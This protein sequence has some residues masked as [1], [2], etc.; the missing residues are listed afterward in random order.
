MVRLRLYGRCRI[1]KDPVSP[2][3]KEP[4]RIGWDGWFR[5][6]EL[7]TPRSLRGR[8]L[9]MRTRGWWT[10]EPSDVAEVVERYGGLVVGD[11]GELMV[12]LENENDATSLSRALEERF[13]DRILLAP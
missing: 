6:I 11:G 3:M 5:N 7:V 1:Y 12:E 8:E 2:V 10:E 9:L 4:A 13:G